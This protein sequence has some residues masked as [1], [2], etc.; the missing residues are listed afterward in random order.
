MNG[1]L[2]IHFRRMFDADP[3]TLN[4]VQRVRP[5][6][7]GTVAAQYRLVLARCFPTIDESGE[8]PDTEFLQESSVELQR[9][10]ELMWQAI[11]CCTGLTLRIDDLS[12]DLGPKGGCS[13]VFADVTVQIQVPPLSVEYVDSSS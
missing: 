13:I 9:D 8:L 4:E 5:C 3:N 1:E 11:A 7:G 10:A 12:V 2:S 6:R